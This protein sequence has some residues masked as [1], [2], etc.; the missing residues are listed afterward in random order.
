MHLSDALE[1]RT[2]QCIRPIVPWRERPGGASGLLNGQINIGAFLRGAASRAVAV[3][4]GRMDG[5]VI[6]SNSSPSP[7]GV[8][9]VIELHPRAPKTSPRWVPASQL[10]RPIPHLGEL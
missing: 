7:L 8:I 1:T 9:A 10:K 6:D 5:T 3:Y 4:G 2:A